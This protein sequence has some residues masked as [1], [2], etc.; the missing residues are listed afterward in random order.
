MNLQSRASS[1]WNIPC[2][3]AEECG[4]PEFRHFLALTLD[5]LN[6][7]FQEKHLHRFK[8]KMPLRF[9]RAIQNIHTQYGDNAANIWLAGNPTC[10][11]VIDRFDEFEGVGQKISTMAVNILVR[12]F[13]V[14]LL[15]VNEID[16]SVDV[17]IDRVYKRIG[18]VPITA[19]RD[20]IIAAARKIYPEYPGFA[21]SVIWEI[22]SDWCKPDLPECSQCFLDEYCPKNNVD[23][24]SEKKLPGK[25]I[26]LQ[27]GII[28]KPASS[29]PPTGKFRPRFAT[30]IRLFQEQMPK[31][32]RT[33]Y[34]S[35]KS[36]CIIY[37]PDLPDGFQYYL[38]DWDSQVSVELDLDASKAPGKERK[39]RAL[40]DRKYEDLSAP[41]LRIQKNWLRLQFFYD[42]KIPEQKIADAM[43]SLIRQ[44][45]TILTGI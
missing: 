40:A 43:N 22:G 39:I 33:K 21:D 42:E 3:I 34:T 1:I 15:N 24:L 18:V 5:D 28:K 11:E 36:N 41:E 23:H 26:P 16:I 20:E 2:R 7:I 19:S 8:G 27:A 38:I 29:A 13:K 6:R 12:E 4:G 25:N 30:I 32:F 45:H 31:G 44:T 9:Y 10:K 35:S 37:A 17:Q 14:P